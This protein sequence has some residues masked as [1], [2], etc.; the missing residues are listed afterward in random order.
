MSAISPDSLPIES[1]ESILRPALWVVAAALSILYFG[2]ALIG[3]FRPPPDTYPDFVQ[4]W[5]SAR[6]YWSGEPIYLPQQE[7]M[8]RHSGRDIPAFAAELSWNAHP[9]VAVLTALP[10]GRIS[11][12]STAHLAWNLATFPL[13]VLSLALVLR[14][15]NIQ[16]RWWSVFAIIALVV[17]CQAVLSQLYQGQLN[18]VILFLLVIAWVADRRGYQVAAGVAVGTAA[19]LKIFPGLLLVYFVAT[20]RWRAAVAALIV[21]LAL[22]AVALA[23]FGLGPFEVYTREILPS[24]NV[25]RGSWRNV[26]LTGYW[27]RVG[28]SLGLPIIGTAGAALCQLT[29]VGIVWWVSR[30][31]VTADD[32]DRAFSLAVI[33]MLLASPVAWSHYFVLLLL[34]LLLL[35]QRLP[36]G[37][38]IGV[39]VAASAVLW[40]SERFF[41][42]LL[43]GRVAVREVTGLSPMPGGLTMAVVGLGPFTYALVGLFLLMAFA[44]FTP[45]D[46]LH[47]ESV[48]DPRVARDG[49]LPEN[50]IG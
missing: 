43:I 19:A 28:V 13:F 18:F 12:Y 49:V 7:A 9:P 25:F 42:E 34:P 16:M 26:S 10:F 17:S 44:R 48:V 4:E 14:E 45:T 3:V 41:P 22:N 47:V 31:A 21:G 30:R 6:N 29:V 32:R 5:L 50:A 37:W 20:G 23:T 27:S 2:P 36:R 11:D 1:R 40:V 46:S 35:W 39:L 15:L 33:G 8:R 24:L 38:A